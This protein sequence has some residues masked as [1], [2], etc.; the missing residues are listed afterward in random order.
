MTPKPIKIVMTIP[1]PPRKVFAALTEAKTIRLWSEQ[2]GKIQPK[3]GG[4]FEMFDGWV[5]G[6]VLEYKPGKALAYTWHPGDWDGTV[7][8]TVRYTF[9][10][11]K[12]GTKVTLTHSGFP[13]EHERK[14]HY[15]GWYEFVFEPLKSY[16]RQQQESSG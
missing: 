1:A 10:A 16:F 3:V 4:K 14:N 6:T 12:S 7:K 5:K 11:T 9:T 8:S 2:G 15:Y 13:N